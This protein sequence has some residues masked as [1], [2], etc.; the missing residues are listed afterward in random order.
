LRMDK[1]C[2]QP[3][4]EQSSRAR[5]PRSRNQGGAYITHLGCAEAVL[6][7]TSGPPS[8]LHTQRAGGF[9]RGHSTQCLVP[10]IKPSRRRRTWGHHRKRRTTQS[11]KT[12]D[13]E[14]TTV[15]IS[16]SHSNQ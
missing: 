16:D 14:I 1:W 10:W 13:L 5:Q 11:K 3:A 7:V 9:S 4:A 12:L 15:A 2:D 6:A 8:V